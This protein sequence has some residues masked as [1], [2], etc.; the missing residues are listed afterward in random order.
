MAIATFSA[1]RHIFFG[2]SMT[3]FTR[4]GEKLYPPFVISGGEWVKIRGWFVLL[5]VC[6]LW[7]S[8]IYEIPLSRPTGPLIV[9]GSARLSPND[10]EIVVVLCKRGENCEYFSGIVPGLL[11][12]GVWIV[13]H[14]LFQPIRRRHA[15]NWNESAGESCR[16]LSVARLKL[17]RVF[18]LIIIS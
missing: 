1:S 2:S 7:R 5:G 9:R 14:K 10:I 16:I 15:W 4:N 6:S 18:Y 12:L 8:D 13:V 11:F 3:L 17:G